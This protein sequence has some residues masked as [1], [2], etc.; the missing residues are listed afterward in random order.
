MAERSR[1]RGCAWTV[2]M[3]MLGLLLGQASASEVGPFLRIETGV[4]EGLIYDVAILSEGAGFVTV[5]AD[6]TARVWTA[7]KLSPVGVIRPPVGP[8]DV[9]ALYA[10]AASDKAI[11]VG[12]RIPDGKPD[13]FAVALYLRSD[14][15][16]YGLIGN[17][18]APVTA[19][20]FSRSGRRLA[21]GM[22]GGGLRV[23]DLAEGKI[24]FRDLLPPGS[25]TGLDF[26]AAD[27][28]AVA[29]TEGIVKLYDPDFRAL[30][31]PAPP[32]SAAPW[33]IAFSPDG[34]QLAIGD[35]KQPSVHILDTRKMQFDADLRGAPLSAGAL[36]VVAYS[37][38][39]KSLFAAGNYID[40]DGQVYIRRFILGPRPAAADIKASHQ[41]VTGVVPLSDGLIA[42]TG[43]PAI[44][45]IGPGGDTAVAV[46]PSHIDF[47]GSVSDA[48]K[49]SQDGTVIE[50]RSADGRRVRFDAAV[51][52]ILDAEDRTVVR[53]AFAASAGLGV[54]G[55]T[56]SH[57]P[58]V[59]GRTLILEQGETAR[60]VSV[61]ANGL[62]AAIGTDFYLR[63]VSRTG[64]IWRIA[65]EAPVWAVNTST[66]NRLV[67]AG[68]GDGTVRWYDAASGK[69]L[70]SLLLQPATE[71]FVVW[72]TQGFFDHDHRS[73][74]H[75]DGR[76]LVGYR[77]NT[78]SGRDSQFVEIGQLY[79]FFFRPDL[80]GLA[81]RNTESGNKVLTEQAARFGGVGMVMA[82]GMPPHAT[83]LEACV[84]SLAGC[85][86]PQKQEL[87]QR[88]STDRAL[89]LTDA[90]EVRLRYQLRDEK[91][92]PGVAI[93]KR[94]EAVIANDVTVVAT[95]PN[96]RT[97]EATV[98]LV[99]GVNRIQIVPVSANGAIEASEADS[100][101]LT[102][103][104]TVPPL[105][106]GAKEPV[107]S[108]MHVLAVGVGT[109]AQPDLKFVLPSLPN[110]RAD[111]SEVAELFRQPSPDLFY[112]SEVS[113]LI[114]S[115]ATRASILSALRAIAA[116]AAPDDIVVL[117]LAGH[118]ESVNEQ[119][120]FVA[121]DLGGGDATAVANWVRPPV[122]SDRLAAKK[123][124]FEASG[125]SQQDLL[126][127]IHA[128]PAQRFALILDTCF[129]AYAAVDFD[130]IARRNLNETVTNRLGHSI[131][132]FVL[133][134]AK[135]KALDAGDGDMEEQGLFTGFL[136]KAFQGEADFEHVGMV[137][138]S[139]LSKYIKRNVKARSMDMAVKENNM[140]LVQEPFSYFAGNDDFALHSTVNKKLRN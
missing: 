91:G 67:V 88:G 77:I 1:R 78:P 26:D 39:G 130:A 41:L 16:S 50:V 137:D 122:G 35:A 3:L 100:T 4:H 110:A 7:D 89:V 85:T 15:S 93:I 126:S 18:P 10:V 92:T 14:L 83:V 125:L 33:V 49:V 129:S 87:R 54:T 25:I 99:T 98:P 113:T 119:Y 57:T 123:A 111:A 60:S 73:D 38:D 75:P 133:S 114:D 109:L 94:N 31:V 112:R 135:R 132:R 101:V 121:Y 105:P 42:T 43:D 51:H 40:K 139:S 72:T 97:E 12:G 95:E 21:V 61:Q 115:Q 47:R 117:F 23:F 28:L 131:G 29:T 55:W 22:H 30:K 74:T 17:F 80:V 84:P 20:R 64:E 45:R 68:M 37:L 13:S 136:L 118:G 52:A 56:N 8:G 34:N 24:V 79:P 124:L 140:E 128:T 58:Q 65:A 106:P 81:L 102:V 11:A 9:G 107:K 44:L 90:A 116:K 19:L 48:L 59:N 138:V 71:R 5:S 96:A 53:P 63:M 62:G 69:E 36:G 134:S 127:A 6:K 66:D 32:K 104:R 103:R 27:R 86:A 46:R 82:G 76:G 2:L 70:L 120:Y 108:V